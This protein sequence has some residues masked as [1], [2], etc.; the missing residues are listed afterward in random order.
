[1]SSGVVSQFITEFQTEFQK[2]PRKLAVTALLLATGVSAPVAHAADLT[3]GGF[4]R[5]EAVKVN[6]AE[7]TSDKSD[8]AYGLHHLVLL[9]KLVAADGLTLHARLD[10]LNDPV[11]GI[12]GNGQIN[13]V[14]GDLLGNGPGTTVSGATGPSTGADS[15]AWGRTM[16]AGTLAITE[17]WASWTQEFGQLTVGRAPI[18]FGLGTA[19]N[20]G[21]GLFDHFIDTRDMVSYKVV[22]GNFSI[23]PMF[24][25]MSEGGL[26]AEDDVDD[27]IVHFQY[28]NPD[29]ELSLG[30]IYDL[31][32][33]LGNDS[34]I[35]PSSTYW[36]TGFTRSGS[37]KNTLMGV[38]LSEKALPWLRA[39][40]EADMLSG[41][42]GVLNASG[43][44]VGLNAF[45]LAAEIATIPSA[46][47]RWSGVFK[48]GMATGDDPGTTDTYEGFAFNRNYD[49]AL[50]MF[51]HPLGKADFMR[52]GMIRK[53]TDAASSQIDTEALSNAIYFA[54]SV[55]YRAKDNLAWGATFVYALLNKDPISATSGSGNAGTATDLGYELDLNVTYKPLERLTWITEAG[56]LL[57]GSA[58]K[59]GSN[60]WENKFAYGIVTKA[61]INF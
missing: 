5:F 3:W 11:H 15:N 45:G 44:G 23:T 58:W 46:E 42:A 8:K 31:R 48:F 61:A 52:T 9:P 53:A 27:Y 13:S 4:Y 51:N 40:V 55:K 50:L 19:F 7:L 49:V 43:A 54:P 17:L 1:M 60:S 18:Q 26:S 12:N 6:N 38:F 34:P 30:F 20:A 41:D 14:A 39:S 21:Q 29:S 36:P 2:L 25:K 10:I 22:L 57:P 56:F 37:F 35:P 33:A 47:D 28:D 59:G 16:R 32:V 24:G